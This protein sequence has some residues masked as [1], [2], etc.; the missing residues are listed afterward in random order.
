MSHLIRLHRSSRQLLLAAVAFLLVMGL[1]S[2]GPAAAHNFTKT[3]GND[4]ASKIDLRS[5]SV[6]HT[7]TGVL[8][9]VTTWN[10]WTPASLQDD[11]WFLIGINKDSDAAYE[12]CAFIYFARRLR[13]LLSEL[14]LFVHPVLARR[15]TIRG[16][17]QDHYPQVRNRRRVQVVRGELLDG[18]SSVSERVSRLHSER[19]P[20]H[21]PR[22][23]TSHGISP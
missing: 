6:S 4:S 19:A 16:D 9:R 8:H 17:G 11:S 20:G 15:E 7:S 14:R 12:R 23:Y 1:L 21:P 13:G 22:P 3:D 5:A 10:A 18:C 2:A